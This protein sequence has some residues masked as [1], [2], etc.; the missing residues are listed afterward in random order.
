MDEE[1]RWEI[2]TKIIEKVTC[3]ILWIDHFVHL[4]VSTERE[5]VGVLS[6]TCSAAKVLSPHLGHGPFPPRYLNSVALHH[7]DCFGTCTTSLCTMYCT[8]CHR[9]NN[10]PV[11]DSNLRYRLSTTLSQQPL[12][13]IV[14]SH[15]PNPVRDEPSVS[16]PHLWTRRQ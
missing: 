14:I 13:C 1:K 3:A 4:F 10:G 11:M 7:A 2:C 6:S 5:P 15:R 9:L 16:R 12:R 8:K